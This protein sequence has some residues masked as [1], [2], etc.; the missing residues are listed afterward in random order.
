[1]TYTVIIG[2]RSYDLPKKTVKVMEE[3]DRVASIDSVRG[4]S[5]RDKFQALYEFICSLVGEENAKE[6]LGSSNLDEVDLSDVTLTFKKIVDA[7]DKPLVEY[8][9]QKSRELIG[10]LPIDKL[11]ELSRIAAQQQNG[12]KNGLKLC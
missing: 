3:M 11:V 12:N 5:I 9:N 4:M 7:Y 10:G 1:M 8:S 2:G 6:I